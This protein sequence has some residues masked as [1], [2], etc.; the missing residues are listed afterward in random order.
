MSQIE[1]RKKNLCDFLPETDIGLSRNSAAGRMSAGH[2]EFQGSEGRMHQNGAAI[3]PAVLEYEDSNCAHR[4]SPALDGLHGS[5]RSLWPEW[6]ALVV[7]AALVALAIP[8]H[9]PWVDEA[10]SWQLARSLSLASLFKT[11]IRYEG[12]PGLWHFL[13]WIMIR[14]HVS[15]TGLHWICGLIATTGVSLLIFR[16]PFPRY[17]RLMFPFTFFL[18]FQYAVVARNY[19]LAPMLLFL[20]A[21]AW[22]KSTP[23]VATG[24]GLLANLSLHTA[25]LSGGLA[26]VY[27]IEQTRNRENKP[28]NNWRKLLLCALV[29]LGLYAFA[30][31]TAWPPH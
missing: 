11:Y 7:Y 8:Y 3:N 27:A 28:D 26:V 20:I 6:S 24:L 19:V 2:A 23:G 9:E 13:L 30:I 29:L 15:Y 14:L 17:L 12:T 16:A 10:Q 5:S 31:W 25:V 21:I 22:K 18:L 4:F 1:T